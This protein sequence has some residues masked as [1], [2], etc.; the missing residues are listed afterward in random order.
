MSDQNNLLQHK[1]FKNLKNNQIIKSR[2]LLSFDINLLDADD[3]NNL[4]VF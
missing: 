4:Q 2:I 3:Q 1:R